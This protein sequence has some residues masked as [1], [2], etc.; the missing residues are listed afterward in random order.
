MLVQLNGLGPKVRNIMKNMMSRC[1]E[2][3]CDE[4]VTGYAHEFLKLSLRAR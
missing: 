3:L 2:R 4:M 1:N